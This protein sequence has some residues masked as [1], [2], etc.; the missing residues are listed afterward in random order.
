MH[1]VVQPNVLPME[2]NLLTEI[3]QLNSLIRERQ[4]VAYEL[5]NEVNQLLASVLLWIRF[6]KTQNKL[7]DDASIM[8]AEKNLQDAIN[9]VRALQ[10]C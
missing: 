1:S 8:N 5:Q 6:A 10:Q 9:R 7:M 3:D 2:T 4:Q